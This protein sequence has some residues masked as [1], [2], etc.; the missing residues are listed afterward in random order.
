MKIYAMQN[1]SPV[2]FTGLSNKTKIVK[3]ISISNP[4]PEDLKKLEERSKKQIEKLG[5]TVIK[6]LKI[7]LGLGSKSK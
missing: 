5:L 3:T 7:S 2:N 6:E 4:T 1:Y